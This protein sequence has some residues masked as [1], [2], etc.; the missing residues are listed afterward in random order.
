MRRDLSPG[1]GYRTGIWGGGGMGWEEHQMGDGLEKLL[2]GEGWMEDRRKH[3]WRKHG[4]WMDGW[5]EEP[6]MVEGWMEEP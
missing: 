5:M 1:E 6:W 4:W 3:G 2:T